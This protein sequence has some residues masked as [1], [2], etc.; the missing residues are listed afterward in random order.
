MRYMPLSS[1]VSTGV[2][3]P[4]PL[5]SGEAKAPA[6]PSSSPQLDLLSSLF[7]VKHRPLFSEGDLV[8][9]R[10]DKSSRSASGANVSVWNKLGQD[11][12]QAVTTFCQTVKQRFSADVTGLT[13]EDNCSISSSVQPNHARIRPIQSSNTT[14]QGS[15]MMA[16]LPQ[17]VQPAVS[18]DIQ[19]FIAREQI[20]NRVIS[21][22][23][24]QKP[25]VNN[26][27]VQQMMDT[28]V[29]RS[30][31]HDR[32]QRLLERNQFLSNSINHLVNGYFQTQE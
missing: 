22:T 4:A 1:N 19:A 5:A 27:L 15:S 29:S 9:I 14:Q 11:I 2:T 20:M 8:Q 25:L 28:P 30:I 13:P 7:P 6:P 10:G 12:N 32:T 17:S 23:R 18:S 3:S 31:E 24:R 21:E 26:A 16:S